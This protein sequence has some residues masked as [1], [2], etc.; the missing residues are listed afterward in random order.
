MNPK[1]TN[2]YHSMGIKAVLSGHKDSPAQDSRPSKKAPDEI[3]MS[4]KN[5][6]LFANENN[7]NQWKTSVQMANNGETCHM[8]GKKTSTA[9]KPLG[10]TEPEDMISPI[11]GLKLLDY[12]TWAGEI[13]IWH[14]CMQFYFIIFHSIS[15][16]RRQAESC[17]GGSECCEQIESKSNNCASR[18]T[19]GQSESGFCF[20]GCQG[21]HG[22]GETFPIDG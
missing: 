3:E 13:M 20:S 4:N 11:T 22:S 7:E 16:R 19:H 6:S 12:G 8:D 10:V 5:N 1:L 17:F 2:S 18:P 15:L 14:T 21:D 9:K